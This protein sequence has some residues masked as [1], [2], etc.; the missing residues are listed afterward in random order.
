MTGSGKSVFLRLLVHQAIADGARLLLA[1]LDGATFPMLQGHLALLAPIAGNPQEA[2]QVVGLALGECDRRA[3]LYATVGGFPDNLGEY[4]T[5]A[6]KGG[7]PALPRVLVVLDEFNATVVAL[8]GARG[9]FAGDVAATAWRGRKFGVNLVVA[10]QDFAKETVGR[11]R[12]QVSSV[13]FRVQSK[14]LAR[15]VG[16]SEAVHITRPGRAVSQ[17]WGAFQ[18]YF[19][20]KAELS[21]ATAGAGILSQAELDMIRWAIEQNDGYL[22]LTDIQERA[23]MLARAG[24]RACEDIGPSGRGYSRR[25]AANW[26][27]RG[28]LQKDATAGNCRRITDELR[29]IACKLQPLKS[30]ET[31]GVNPQ[32]C[33]AQAVNRPS[34]TLQTVNRLETDPARDPLAD[35]AGALPQ[36]VGLRRVEVGR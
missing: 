27:N 3:A 25:L 31:V 6:V 36:V 5:A 15:Q 9:Q 17:R 12:D 33:N 29:Q 34:G 10:A 20:D 28:W 14:E 21:A 23:H 24:A 30:L 7:D 18:A 2:H 32:A 8:G 35:V 11:F 26:E 4:N 16:C 19:L 22:G 13:C 1:D